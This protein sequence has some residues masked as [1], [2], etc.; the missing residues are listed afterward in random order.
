MA[1]RRLLAREQLHESLSLNQNVSLYMG[2]IAGLQAALAVLA[3]I[4]LLR[5]SQWPHLVGFSALGAL[6][7]LFGRFAPMLKRHGVVWLCALQL[8]AAVFLISLVSWWGGSGTVVVLTVALV[9]AASSVVFNYWQLGGPGAVIIVFAAGAAMSPV[10]AWN[11]VLER[12]LVTATGGVVA[13]LLTSATDFLRVPELARIQAPSDPR[14][15]LKYI[16]LV[17]GRIGVGAAVLGDCRL[18][19]VFSVRDRGNH[20]L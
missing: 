20:W 17:G 14:R 6:A 19:G 13:W 15:P 9:A 5:H 3:A 7:A 10:D 12:T 2:G 11:V 1:A 16:L 8:T 18:R 4:V